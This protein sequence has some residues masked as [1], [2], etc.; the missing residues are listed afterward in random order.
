MSNQE[1]RDLRRSV[2]ARD[3]GCCV[4]CG[5]V[6]ALTLHHIRPRSLGGSH[7]RRNLVTLCRDC[8]D[9]VEGIGRSCAAFLVWIGGA[10]VF[11]R[12]RRRV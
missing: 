3:G 8:H 5:S 10:L 12:S 9:N 1:W 7:T 11:F 4:F 6:D 2:L